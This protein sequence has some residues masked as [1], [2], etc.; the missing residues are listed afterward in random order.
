MKA[1]LSEYNPA[2]FRLVADSAIGR[3]GQPWFVPDFGSGWRWKV[4]LAVRIG[5]LG[6]CI[7][8]KFARRYFD[9]MT[10]LFVPDCDAPEAPVLLGCM[11]GAIV[12][13]EWSELADVVSVDGVGAADFGSFGFENF[14]ALVS[15][16]ITLKTGDLLAID[17]P[18]VIWH[19]AVANSRVAA[20]LNGQRALAFNIK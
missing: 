2:G 12:C 1:L 6:K 10:L 4:M 20:L 13:G 3:N 5:R 14:A 18:E 8:S 7:A 9:A 15:R 16:C 19:E 11:D 17:L